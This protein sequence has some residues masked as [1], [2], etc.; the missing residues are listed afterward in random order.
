MKTFK[1]KKVILCPEC[2]GTK[3]ITFRWDTHLNREKI[4]ILRETDL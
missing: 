1:R 2:K 3:K 4:G